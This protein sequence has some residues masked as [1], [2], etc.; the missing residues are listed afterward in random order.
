M[1][2][3][4]FAPLFASGSRAE[5]PVAGVV[6]GAK[7]RVAISGQVDRLAVAGDRVLIVDYK[8]NRPPPQREADV[9]AVYLRQM[10]AYRA[11]LAEIYPRHRIDCFL[12]WTDGPR[13]MHISPA[14]L[15]AHAP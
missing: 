13:L 12:L 1:S 7:G 5:V 11:L 2:E 10:A 14:R 4:E 6:E 3:P 8:T 15:A 9:P